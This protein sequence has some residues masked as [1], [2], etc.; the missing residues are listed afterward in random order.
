MCHYGTPRIVRT[1]RGSE[2]RGAFAAYLREMGI[3]QQTILP[4]HPRANGLVE[5]YNGLVLAGL[6]RM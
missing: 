1:D 2:F 5:R 6:R 3:R 4:Q